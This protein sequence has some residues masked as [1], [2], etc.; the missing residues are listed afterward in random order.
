MN[1][2]FVNW[3][4]IRVFCF[5]HLSRVRTLRRWRLETSKS[6]D[7]IRCNFFQREG[8]KGEGK[9]ICKK[10]VIVQYAW[11]RKWCKK[12]SLKINLKGPEPLE[13]IQLKMAL[14]YDEFTRIE[15]ELTISYWPNTQKNMYNG[16]QKWFWKSR[17]WKKVTS[18]NSYRCNRK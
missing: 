1:N 8:A 15:I 14:K 3:I 4:Y 9:L 7:A 12:K 10:I 17:Y 16:W 2:I 13:K 11:N 6:T 5:V 18:L